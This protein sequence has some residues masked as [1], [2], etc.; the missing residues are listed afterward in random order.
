MVIK[1]PFSCFSLD[2]QLNSVCGVEETGAAAMHYL[3]GHR[4][5]IDQKPKLIFGVKLLQSHMLWFVFFFHKEAADL[6]PSILALD[7]VVVQHIRQ[8]VYR[9]KT[10]SRSGKPYFS[11]SLAPAE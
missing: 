9:H 3:T 1:R 4:A 6:P 5:Q 10:F 2:F 8:A 11:E 7:A